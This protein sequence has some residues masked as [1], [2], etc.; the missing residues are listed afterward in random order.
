M[1]INAHRDVS[2]LVAITRNTRAEESK[3]MMHVQD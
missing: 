3:E 2:S 1:S